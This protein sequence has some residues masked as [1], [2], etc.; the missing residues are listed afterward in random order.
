VLTGT[1]L[2]HDIQTNSAARESLNLATRLVLLQPHGMRELPEAVRG[3]STAIIQSVSPLRSR[4]APRRDVWEV[5]V[6]GHLR[7]VKDPF[8]TALAARRL[9]ESSRLHVT[10][11]GAALS[12][13]ME[14]RARSEMLI[15]PRYE[16]LGDLPHWQCRRRLARSRLLVLTSKME[17]GANAVC[18]AL[19]DGVPVISSRIPGSIGILGEDYAGYFPVGDTRALKELLL[20]CE[21]DAAFYDTLTDWCRR[22]QPL[23]DPARERRMWRELLSD[24]TRT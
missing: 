19:A 22:L 14:Q 9:P 12:P 17:G 8:R 5:S 20:R 10:H 13:D 7:P 6:V 16:W 2:Y 15:N 23:V 1:D 11:L 24:C 21:Q 18:E 3:K 4:P